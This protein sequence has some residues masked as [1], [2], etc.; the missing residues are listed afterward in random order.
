MAQN[1]AQGKSKEKGANPQGFCLT[2]WTSFLFRVR[3]SKQDQSG[4]QT[5]IQERR[6][7]FSP[8]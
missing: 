6:L 3:S 4:I 1:K 7:N 2:P 5:L 8:P